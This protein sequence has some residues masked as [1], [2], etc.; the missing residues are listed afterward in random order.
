[1]R[2][3]RLILAL[4]DYETEGCRFEPCGVYFISHA[5]K[6]T[7]YSEFYDIELFTDSIPVCDLA[8]II[9]YDFPKLMSSRPSGTPVIFCPVDCYGSARD[10]DRDGKWLFQCHQILIHSEFLRKY[11]CAYAPVEYIDHHVR[12][13]SK[14]LISKPAE[15]P[16]LW[17]GLRSNLPPLIEWVNHHA[18]PQELWIPTTAELIA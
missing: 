2:H 14:I 5:E 13:I 9:K 16:I 10:I 6:T 12:F 18:L 17:T 11:F 15:G 1:M 4:G 8:I 7:H 3:R